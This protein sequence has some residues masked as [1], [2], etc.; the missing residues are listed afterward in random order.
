MVIKTRDFGEINAEE[1][2]IIRFQR[3]VLGFEGHS[4]YLLLHDESMGHGFAWLQ[5][6]EEPELCFILVDPSLVMPDYMPVLPGDTAALLG[7]N[8]YECWVLATIRESLA[9]S[10]VNLRSP[11][12]INPE[13]WLA[14]QL[15]LE[16][17]YPVRYPLTKEAQ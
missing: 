10:T 17:D 7:A 13:T 15:V 4:R 3:P 14:G 2:N 8:D 5:S 9:K 12:V 16:Q 1:Q 6:A 11:I